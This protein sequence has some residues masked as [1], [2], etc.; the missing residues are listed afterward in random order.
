MN[1]GTIPGLLEARCARS[2]AAPAF[3]TLGQDKRWEPV[4]WGQFAQKVACMGVALIEA[5]IGKDD[6]VGIFAPTSLD[7]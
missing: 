5:G 1:P 4:S 6:R 2:S 3:Y 7:W